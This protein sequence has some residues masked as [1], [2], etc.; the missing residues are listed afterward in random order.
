MNAV[1]IK[2]LVANSTELFSL[3]DIYFQ[4]REMISDSRFSLAEIG[5]VITKDPALS[6]RLLRIVNS[7]FY[8]FQA[9]IDTVSRAIAIIGI[10]D[11]HHL[12]LA[13]TV[14]DR[15]S[16]IPDDLID[17]TS[18][19]IRSMNS[20]VVARMLAKQSAVLHAERLFMAGL[21]HDIGSLLLSQKLPEQ[22]L[23]VLLAANHERALLA[24][25]EK[26]L[27]G[28]TH[29]DVGRELLKS[30]GLPESLHETIGCYLNPAEAQVHKL[31][32]HLLHLATLLVD[33]HAEENGIE[34]ALERLSSQTLTLVRLDKLQI[35]EI[36]E[37]ADEEFLQLFELLAPNKKFH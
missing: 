24:S 23:K 10:D 36:M 22:Y 33:C 2:Q 14:V 27:I 32:T 12:V 30:W 20:A 18:F 37:K 9:R 17:M 25:F 1:A 8:G 26:Q 11:L 35:A 29:A 13:T 19:W 15:F 4:L 6:A 3:P 28:Y 31:D 21:L 5:K 16:K 34:T 7:P